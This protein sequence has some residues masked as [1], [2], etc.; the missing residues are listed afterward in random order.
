[1]YRMSWKRE[2]MCGRETSPFPLEE[3]ISE[4]S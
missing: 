2:E 1:M 3:T 4:L